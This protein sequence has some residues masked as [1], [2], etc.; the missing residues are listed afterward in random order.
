MPRRPRVCPGGMC[1]HVL[2]RAVA[3]LALFE[4]LDDDKA[5]R[6][7]RERP[8]MSC[9]P[10]PED[11]G[12]P[13]LPPVAPERWPMDVKMC[14]P[15]IATNSACPPDCGSSSTNVKSSSCTTFT[16]NWHCFSE[17]TEAVAHPAW[18]DG[19]INATQPEATGGPRL[20]PVAPERGPMDVKMCLPFVATNS[21]S[22]PDCGSSSTN[23]NSPSCT[24]F[25][26]NW[27]CFSEDSEAVAHPA[28][29]DGLINATQPAT[30]ADERDAQTEH[31]ESSPAFRW[32]FSA[33]GQRPGC[34]LPSAEP[35]TESGQNRKIPGAFDAES[36]QLSDSSESNG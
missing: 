24:T 22:P 9:V 18:F 17:D 33:G 31:G 5:I 25:T 3:R 32:C 26:T 35:I 2:N 10:L 23:V 1:F 21:A 13:R 34:V 19:L 16:T 20:P 8:Q 36:R 6:P 11:T 7:Q 15:I 12:G 28:W 27:H 4:K 30:A 29:F 14:L